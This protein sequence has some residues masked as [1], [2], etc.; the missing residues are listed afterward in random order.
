RGHGT[1][2]GDRLSRAL[3]LILRGVGR[4]ITN[5]P[6]SGL[7]ADSVGFGLGF[8]FASPKGSLALFRA[9]MLDLL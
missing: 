7:T 3:A 6:F 9:A 5:L 4:F 2:S 8:R 1:D